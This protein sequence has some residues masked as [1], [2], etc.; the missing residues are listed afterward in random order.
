MS[1]YFT[2]MQFGSVTSLPDPVS[3]VPKSD[4]FDSIWVSKQWLG[5]WNPR[6]DLCSVSNFNMICLICQYSINLEVQ[7]YLVVWLEIVPYLN[8][9]L[10]THI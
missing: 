8:N 5:Q 10:I 1:N 7:S 2:P 9:Q 3:P 6:F 4:Q